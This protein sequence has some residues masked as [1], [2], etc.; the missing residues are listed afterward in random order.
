MPEP[1]TMIRTLSVTIILILNQIVYGQG[2]VFSE[3]SISDTVAGAYGYDARLMALERIYETNSSFTDSIQI[4]QAAIDT[5][6]FAYSCIF[7]AVGL[8]GRDTIIEQ[9]NIKKRKL[10]SLSSILMIVDTSYLW[11]AKLYE[12]EIPCGKPNMDSIILKHN[13]R[14]DSQYSFKSLGKYRIRL[15]TEESL[16][17]NI[18]K[19]LL[20]TDNQIISVSIED[21]ELDGKDVTQFVT[22]TS[23]R[24]IFMAGY[25]D[26]ISGCTYRRYWEFEV[27]FDCSVL[28]KGSYGNWLVNIKMSSV[29]EPKIYPNPSSN[30]INIELEENSS[31]DYKLIDTNGRIVKFEYNLKDSPIDVNNIKPGLYFLRLEWR[32]KISILPVVIS[33]K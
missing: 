31:F 6:L 20:E 17:L 10:V 4:S 9:F 21:W 18:Y 13:F 16:N 8:E 33:N 27:F 24:L 5:F 11:A 30:H 32:D 28:Y 14:I 7:N 25:G 3:C 26:C 23:I 1:Y 29:N 19:E 15:V 2:K 22:D 12:G